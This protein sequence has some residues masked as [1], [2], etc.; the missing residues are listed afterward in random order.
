MLQEVMPELS[1]EAHVHHDKGGGTFG[2]FPGD[3]GFL[4]ER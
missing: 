2:R 1:P 3:Y 4:M